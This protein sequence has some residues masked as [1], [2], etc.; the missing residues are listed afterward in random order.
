M[1]R[2]PR[3]TSYQKLQTCLRRLWLLTLLQSLN[4]NLALGRRG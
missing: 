3:A 2:M 4:Q 1:V